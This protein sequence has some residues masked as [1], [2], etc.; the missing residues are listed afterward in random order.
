VGVRAQRV[1][2]NDGEDE[3]CGDGGFH[4]DGFKG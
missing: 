3:G 4:K 1:C 2:R